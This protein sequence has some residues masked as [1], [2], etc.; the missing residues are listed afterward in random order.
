MIWIPHFRTTPPV[1]SPGGR[2]GGHGVARDGGIAGSSGCVGKLL[3]PNR[4]TGTRISDRSKLAIMIRP[5]NDLTGRRYH[6]VLVLG[7]GKQVGKVTYWRCL[8]DC[9]KEFERAVSGLKYRPE[10]TRQSCGC[11]KRSN[12]SETNGTHR[13]TNTRLFNI[14]SSMKQRCMNPSCKSYPQYGGRGI[15]VCPRWLGPSGFENFRSDMGGPPVGKSIDRYPRNDGNYE[16]G[17]CRWATPKEQAENRRNRQQPIYELNGESLTLTAI[18]E[19]SGLSRE[20]VRQRLAAG[21]SLS[22]ATSARRLRTGPRSG[23]PHA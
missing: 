11:L 21:Y 23:R 18:A 8:C 3:Q 5:Q 20:R 22:V 13:A 4:N 17:N 19:R 7:L 6:M 16:P 12:P 2:S 10:G 9:G 15:A 1:P 14:W